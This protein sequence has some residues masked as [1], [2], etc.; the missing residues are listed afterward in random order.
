MK[1]PLNSNKKINDNNLLPLVNIIFLLL[2]FFMIAGVIQKQ[3]ELYNVD[4]GKATIDNYTEREINTLFINKDGSIILNDE[5]VSFSV[6]EKTI[7]QLNKKSELLIA[8]DKE[9]TAA[10]LNRI[11]L[12]L[13]N[14]SIKKIFLMTSKNDA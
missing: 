10:K 8:A 14:Q 7:S 13:N 2:I 11:L 9:L 4:L 1:L 5:D 6:F 12:I 3:K